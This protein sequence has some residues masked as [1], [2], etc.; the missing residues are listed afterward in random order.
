MKAPATAST[1]IINFFI[2]DLLAIVSRLN[3]RTGPSETMPAIWVRSERS[4]AGN[5]HREPHV[6]GKKKPRLRVA[7]EKAAGCTGVTRLGALRNPQRPNSVPLSLAVA[8]ELSDKSE[9]WPCFV[10]SASSTDTADNRRQCVGRFERERDRMTVTEAT[11][12]SR[13]GA[14]APGLIDTTI[15][16]GYLK[17]KEEADPTSIQLGGTQ[18]A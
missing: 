2:E 5:C 12:S 1:A 16:D 3:A 8:G 4:F 17:T 10:P 18:I 13:G 14:L 6:A 15:I 7:I 11:L 9:G